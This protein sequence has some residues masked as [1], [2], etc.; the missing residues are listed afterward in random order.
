MKDV[1]SF[2]A[3]SYSLV[4]FECSTGHKSPIIKCDIVDWET[5]LVF[6][7]QTLTFV[8]FS[9]F[10]KDRSREFN[11]QWVFEDLLLHEIKAFLPE[12]GCCKHHLL[13]SLKLVRNPPIDIRGFS[14]VSCSLVPFKCRGG[15]K[16]SS[17]IFIK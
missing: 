6:L 14:A 8:H 12:F 5:L 15:K 1:F 4:P 10:F 11:A 2:S 16:D 7:L 17:S 3:V 9:R 13:R